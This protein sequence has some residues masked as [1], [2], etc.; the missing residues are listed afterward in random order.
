M[1]HKQPD[2]LQLLTI[3]A[4]HLPI[5]HRGLDLNR[6]QL[7]VLLLPKV[8]PSMSAQAEQNLSLSAV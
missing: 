6:F 5:Q 2:F 1:H 8:I 7:I 3:A 4:S